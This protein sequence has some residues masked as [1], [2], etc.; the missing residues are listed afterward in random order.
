MSKDGTPN[1]KEP[2]WKPQRTHHGADLGGSSTRT[3]F[4]RPSEDIDAY[5]EATQRKGS[6]R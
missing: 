6:K 4:R 5:V 2:S 3:G 1:R